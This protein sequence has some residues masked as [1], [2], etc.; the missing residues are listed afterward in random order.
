M[1]IALFLFK[2]RYEYAGNDH[3]HDKVLP[4]VIYN[5][6]CKQKIV[7]WIAFEEREL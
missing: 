7:K 1:H 4:L 6:L 5:E 3:D 2:Q